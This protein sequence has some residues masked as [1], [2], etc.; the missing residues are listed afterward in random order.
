MNKIEIK[1]RKFIA[2]LK[3][4]KKR[5][6]Q[7]ELIGK[8]TAKKIL[9]LRDELVDEQIRIERDDIGKKKELKIVEEKIKLLDKIICHQQENQE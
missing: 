9:L 5:K 4:L 6:N 8:I 1:I 3:N 2:R 7:E